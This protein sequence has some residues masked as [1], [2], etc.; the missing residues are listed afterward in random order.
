MNGKVMSIL[1][2]LEHY[3]CQVTVTDE[4][5]DPTE[6]KDEYGV[7]LV[8]LD[9]LKDQDSVIITVGHEQY[10]SF[11]DQDWKRMLK[12]NGVIIDVKSLYSKDSFTNLNI[13]HWRL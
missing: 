4:W 13:R 10:T 11:T 3:K 7:D 6:A 2:R 5:A 12:P 1:K 9:E 8:K